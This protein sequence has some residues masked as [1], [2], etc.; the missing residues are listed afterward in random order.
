[1][2]AI[3]YLKLNENKKILFSILV[4]FL[5]RKFVVEFFDVNKI[6]IEH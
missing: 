3:N 6:L 1:M 2:P 5:F 4:I